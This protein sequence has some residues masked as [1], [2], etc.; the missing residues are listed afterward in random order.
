[1]NEVGAVV[2]MSKLDGNE[3]ATGMPTSD[4]ETKLLQT[5]N[6]MRSLKNENAKL[7]L[8]HSENDPITWNDLF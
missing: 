8:P 3:S 6:L 5:R 2:G 4:A 7:R 1:V